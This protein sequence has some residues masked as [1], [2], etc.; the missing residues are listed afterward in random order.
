MGLG[1]CKGPAALWTL[2]SLG[3]MD[4]RVDQV[5]HTPLLFTFKETG[6]P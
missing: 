2:A 4:V 5:G 1:A 3:R 6:T